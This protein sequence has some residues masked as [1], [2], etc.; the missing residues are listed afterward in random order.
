[1]V[2]FTSTAIS[3]AA[4]LGLI[5]FCPAPFLA[6]IVP[7]AIE[8]ATAAAWV[9]AAGGVL[10]G[11][12][13]AA[14]A[15]EAAKGKK[16]DVTAFPRDILHSRVKRQGTMNELAWEECHSDLG[17]ATVGF[18]APAPGSKLNISSSDLDL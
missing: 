8:G 17:S 5:Q 3:A 6:A 12:A 1:M 14:Q 18:S 7:V 4:L 11:G 10:G 2:S 15:V 13:A 9:G 16:R